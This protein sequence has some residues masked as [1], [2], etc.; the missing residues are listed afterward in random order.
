VPSQIYSFE[1]YCRKV[2]KLNNFLDSL[3]DQRQ[4]P[5]INIR[6]IV[7][8]SL[9]GSAL[10]IKAFSAIE[11]E[12][13]KGILQKRT[14]E[15]SDDTFGYGLDFL[16]T[17]SL[18]KGW[19]QMLKIMKR[20]GMLRNNDFHDWIVGVLDGI[21]TIS[22][23][24][25]HCD[26]CLTRTVTVDKKK[27]TQYYHRMVVLIIVGYEFPIPIGLEMLRPGED[28]VSCGINLL[29]RL[30]KAL[31]V[32]FLDLV[33]GDALYCTPRFFEE[34]RAMKLKAGAVLKDNQK[35]L[36]L[37]AQAQLKLQEPISCKTEEKEKIQFWDLA[38]VDWYTAGKN[39]RVIWAERE[40]LQHEGKGKNKKLMW[41]PK[42]KVFAFC[43]DT[44]PLPA[45]IAYAMGDHRWDIDASLFQDMVRNWHIKHPTLHFENA[46]EN[47]LIIRLLA[48]FLF[49]FYLHRHIN[50]RRKHEMISSLQMARI[51]YRSACE[52]LQP[53]YILLL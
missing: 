7:C 47:M 6:N 11:E 50:A 51:L 40:V 38:E 39:V 25:R 8:A 26:R 53:K 32:R 28:E 34:C 18:Q 48:Y 15:I 37:T 3:V 23:Y 21:E 49:M 41:V 20:N 33:I 13:K 30:T 44:A 14:G 5:D 2:F 36:L 45:N 35:D 42:R 12:C 10:R 16:S 31:G 9:F 1:R 4:E 46:Y 24:D 43:Q 52:N 29:K 22:S 17:A 27:V 19:M